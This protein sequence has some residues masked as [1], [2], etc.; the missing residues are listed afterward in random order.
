MFL[1]TSNVQVV[2]ME[3]DTLRVAYENASNNYMHFCLCFNKLG[4]LKMDP[5]C[6]ID[7]NNRSAEWQVM[8]RNR[9]YWLLTL[10]NP[11]G[12]LT[13]KFRSALSL[14]FPQYGQLMISPTV[15]SKLVHH[16]LQ[17][18]KYVFEKEDEEKAKQKHGGHHWL[19][20]CLVGCPLLMIL[21]EL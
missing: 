14:F 19:N 18:H 20:S 1:D 7:W 15:F 16:C 11:F 21:E 17:G 13:M 6:F 10:K 3:K 4:M 8:S 2:E 9:Y 5:L 12:E